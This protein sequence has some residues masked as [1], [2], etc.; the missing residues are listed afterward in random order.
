MTAPHEG[1]NELLLASCQQPNNFGLDMDF[2][3]PLHRMFN[4]TGHTA[5]SFAKAPPAA[6]PINRTSTK[7]EAANHQIKT[8]TAAPPVTMPFDALMPNSLSVSVR[9]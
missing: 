1:L 7:A 6:A 8:S 3:V 5:A 4:P 2:T 9:K